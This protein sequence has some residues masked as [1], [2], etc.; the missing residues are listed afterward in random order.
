MRPL[1]MTVGGSLKNGIVLDPVDEYRWCR[2]AERYDFGLGSY[3]VDLTFPPRPKG[4][5]TRTYQRLQAEH[6]ALLRGDIVRK[7]HRPP[8]EPRI[9]PARRS[10]ADEREPLMRKAVD[11]Y[12]AELEA[13]GKT[14]PAS[15]EHLRTAF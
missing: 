9:V 4:M 8:K 14:L 1:W 15:L 10:P 7:P 11:E 6:D 12:A 13:E 5:H 3:P 2:E